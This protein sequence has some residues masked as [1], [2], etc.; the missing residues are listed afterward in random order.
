MPE[1]RKE[2]SRDTL[3]R[4]AA[5]PVE[6]DEG[7]TDRIRRFSRVV[8]KSSLVLL[9]VLA[10]LSCSESSGCGDS[11]PLMPA[12]VSGPIELRVA[13]VS[14]MDRPGRDDLPDLYT[15]NSRGTDIRRLTTHGLVNI[16]RWSPNGQELAYAELIPGRPAVS[17][18]VMAN[19]VIIAADGSNPR[20]ISNHATATDGYPTWSPDGQRIAFHSNRH[21]T[22]QTARRSIFVMNVDGS[23]V[24][25]LTTNDAWNDVSPHWSPDGTKIAFM[26]NRSGGV[27]QIFVMNADGSNQQQLTTIG[28]NRWPNWSPDGTKIAFSSQRRTDDTPDNGIY[29]MNPD[30][31]DQTNLTR[32]VNMVD[33][34]STWSSDGREI[35][36]SGMRAGMHVN[37]VTVATGVVRQ[38]TS[39]G[40]MAMENMPNATWPRTMSAS[41][42]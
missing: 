22:T 31:S 40:A 21:N 24:V 12:C 34:Y 2:V 39:F 32:A 10:L 15:M 1:F 4:L 16:V 5:R 33:M 26:S 37:K 3:K 8:R 27:N 9:P 35:Y 41:V 19:L 17:G 29:L 13:F 25:R 23:N 7:R 6:P 38:V 14:N 30:G 42:R 18:V 11:N 28:I 36:F 20:N